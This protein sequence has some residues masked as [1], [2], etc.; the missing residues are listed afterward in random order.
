[1]LLALQAARTYTIPV[2]AASA[3]ILLPVRP[4]RRPD[5]KLPSD[6]GKWD[7]GR[8]WGE[9]PSTRGEVHVSYS[10]RPYVQI[11]L[12]NRSFSALV[13]TGAE[14]S[15]ID[16]RILASLFP[17]GQP[18]L[19]PA[20]RL[21][22]ADNSQGTALGSI[23]LDTRIGTYRFQH[24]FFV[25][26]QLETSIIIGVDLWARAPFTIAP[27]WRG[28][29]GGGGDGRPD[30]RCRLA[31]A[32]EEDA[33]REFLKSELAKFR[34]VRGPTDQIEHVIRLTNNQPIKQRYRPRNPAMQGVIDEEVGKMLR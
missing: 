21:R 29:A 11:R 22:F 5:Q 15:C 13:D 30:R 17:T 34:D 1:M 6:D 7:E 26:S 2:P 14:L 28:C 31:A 24:K 3:P 16:T 32:S 20:T 33:L 12:G 25:L 23:F 8:G 19:R 9:H 18:S 27:P 10:P 4:G